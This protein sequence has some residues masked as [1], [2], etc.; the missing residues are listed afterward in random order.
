MTDDLI[1]V[2]FILCSGLIWWDNVTLFYFYTKTFHG[3]I[4]PC[5]SL[6][7]SHSLYLTPCISSDHSKHAK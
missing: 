6:P 1:Y 2:L 5:I 7:V 4:T 3:A